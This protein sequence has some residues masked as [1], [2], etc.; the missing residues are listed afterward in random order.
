MSIARAKTL[1]AKYQALS[2]AAEFIISH[3]E[4]GF[5]FQDEKFNDVYLR[6]KVKIADKLNRQAVEYLHKY[7]KLGIQVD[8]EI[9]ENY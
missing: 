1:M 2:N 3:G 4:E 7:R 6:E 8:S 5:S 9:N